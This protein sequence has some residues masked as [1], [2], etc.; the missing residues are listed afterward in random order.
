[1]THDPTANERRKRRD[2]PFPRLCPNCLKDEV[3]PE[4]MP[5]SV[6]AKHD[7]RSYRIEVPELRIPKCKACGELIFT[8]SVDDQIIEALRSRVRILT[9]QQIKAGRKAL[10][11]KSKDLA[12]R[13]GVA[14]ATLS[15]W[16]KGAMIQ[17]RA[18]DNLLRLY[19]AVP[20]ARV[21]LRG[22]EQDPTLGV[23]TVLENGPVQAGP[24]INRMSGHFRDVNAFRTA[25]VREKVKHAKSAPSWDPFPVE[26]N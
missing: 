7:G 9:P 18:M 26:P 6:E 4:T 11:L 2:K 1:M 24:E 13:L 12:L 8:N 15:R 25:E 20:E 10:G 16:E 5:Y 3:Y 19:F 23:V 17:S 22:V 14:A 21:V